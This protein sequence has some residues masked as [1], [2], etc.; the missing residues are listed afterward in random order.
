MA[1]EQ[2]QKEYI[3]T[4]Y[5]EDGSQPIQDK[6]SLDYTGRAQVQYPNG[7][8][9][10]GFFQNGLKHG[11]GTYTYSDGNKF[12]GEWKDNKK[13][14]IGKMTYG[15]YAEYNG[16]FENGK[17]DGEG[18]YKFLKSGDLYS[19]S[20]KNGMKHGR[21]TFIFSDTRMKIVGDWSNGQIT[22]GKWIFSNGTYFEGRFENNFPKGEGVWHFVNGNTVKGEFTQEMRD[23]VGRDGKETVI[24]W[25]TCDCDEKE[26]LS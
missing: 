21:G 3:I 6:S 4:K 11:V 5:P 7:D 24:N 1:E 2:E 23:A 10:D 26:V 18:V 14:G 8:I 12:E 17:R 19:G 16:H 25:R 13:T 22:Q 20:W 9:F 15:A